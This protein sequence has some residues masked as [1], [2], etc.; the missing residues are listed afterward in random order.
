MGTF[1]EDMPSPELA[2]ANALRGELLKVRTAF[3][4]VVVSFDGD[5]RTAVVRAAIDAQLADGSGAE[6]PLLVDVPVSFPTG[7]GFVIEWPLKAGDEG[8]VIINDRCID[9]WFASG[10]NGPPLDLRMHDLSDASFIPGIRSKP[11]VPGGFDAGALV[12]RQIDGPARFRMDSG[13]KIELDGA[14]FRVK[15]PAIFEQLLRYQAGMAGEGGGAGTQI[16]GDI[17]HS[18]GTITSNGVTV[19]QHEHPVLGNRTGGPEG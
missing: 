5:A 17:N 19:D 15:C 14:Q 13:G 3:P 12:I 18:G 9:G 6:L 11:N 8:Q 4:G 16:T 7:G 1:D 10:R 2:L